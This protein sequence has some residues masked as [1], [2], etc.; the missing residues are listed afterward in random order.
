M[1]TKYYLQIV[2][3][4]FVQNLNKGIRVLV[5]TLNSNQ[6]AYLPSS[7]AG[8]SVSSSLAGAAVVG[9]VSG[10][11]VVGV[12]DSSVVVVSTKVVVVSVMVVVVSVTGIG[13]FKRRNLKPRYLVSG[14]ELLPMR[15]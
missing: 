1:S 5:T 14:L 11:V 9:V 3:T 8:A 7:A 2:Q 12:V 10:T 15:T 13:R 6:Q 4:D